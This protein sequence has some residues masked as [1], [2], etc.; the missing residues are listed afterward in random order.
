MMTPLRVFISTQLKVFHQRLKTSV[1]VFVVVL[2]YS[3][4][5]FRKSFRFF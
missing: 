4:F 1:V 5:V 3:L 2:G